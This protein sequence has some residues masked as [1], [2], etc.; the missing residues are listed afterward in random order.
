M[1]DAVANGGGE[2]FGAFA[3]VY[4]AMLLFV[5]GI[6]GMSLINS[7]FVDAMV[8]DNNDEVLEKLNMIE[9]QLQELSNK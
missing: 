4:F 3:K 9:K 8:S 1:P 6:I 7:I 5:G 2:I